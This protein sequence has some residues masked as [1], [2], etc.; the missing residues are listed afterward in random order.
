MS[1]SCT[2]HLS[3]HCCPTLQLHK[4]LSRRIPQHDCHNLTSRVTPGLTVSLCRHSFQELSQSK[5]VQPSSV[6]CN[7][8]AQE[9]IFHIHT[10]LPRF[11]VTCTH[12]CT[13]QYKFPVRAADWQQCHALHHMQS[14]SV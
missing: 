12:S 9:A 3:T 5:V 7:D 11:Q 10:S 13:K 2:V 4:Q 1:Q 8:I 14:P 6:T